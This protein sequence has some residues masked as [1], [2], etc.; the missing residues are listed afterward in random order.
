MA[1]VTKIL[2]NHRDVPLTM[3]SRFGFGK[4]CNR[5]DAQIPNAGRNKNV[6]SEGYAE[7]SSNSK[8]KKEHE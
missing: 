3:A 4:E 6:V 7:K 2:R 8:G 1:D 5:H